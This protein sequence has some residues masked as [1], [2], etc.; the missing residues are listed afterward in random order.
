MKSAKTFC[1]Q[2]G[3]VRTPRQKMIRRLAKSLCVAHRIPEGDELVIVLGEGNESNNLKAVETWVDKSLL[4]IDEPTVREV[5][6]HL[7]HRLGDD[8]DQWELGRWF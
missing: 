1:E 5:L 8:L 4:N 2:A 6:N 7:L 3:L